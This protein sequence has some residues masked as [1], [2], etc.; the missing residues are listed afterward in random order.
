VDAVT[1]LG[2]R[3]VIGV[4]VNALDYDDA[5][6]RIL[7]A[8]R[9]GRRFSVSALAVHGVMTGRSNREHR[10]RLNHLDMATPDGQPVRWA[11]NA[12]HRTGLRDRVYGPTLMLRVCDVAAREGLPVFLYGSTDDVL[13]GLSHNLRRRFPSL[14]IVGAEPSRFR[15]LTSVE[16]REIADR[17]LRSGARITFVGLGCPRQEVFVHEFRDSLNM[18][19]LAVGAAFDYHS[20]S[21]KEPPQ[22]V[23]R[24]GLQWAYRL[25]QEPRRLWKRYLLLNPAYAAL[26]LAQVLRLWRP[27][28]DDV[29]P[30]KQELGY[31]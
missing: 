7:A 2:K 24:W 23:Q 15:A 3:N 16:K 30:P 18:P 1:D 6:S 26:V 22:V 28:T 12:L 5:T 9:D 25:V 27:R 13:R 14:E 11:L 4:L 10:Y 8:A 20:G 31:G 29:G 17:I 19:I 21:V